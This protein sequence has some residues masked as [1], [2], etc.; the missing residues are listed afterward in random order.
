MLPRHML[1]LK[2]GSKLS[3]FFISKE[4]MALII[5]SPTIRVP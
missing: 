3:E 4:L 5:S 2:K 1:A